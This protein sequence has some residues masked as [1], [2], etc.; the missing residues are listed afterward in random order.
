[1]ITRLSKVVNILIGGS[2][3]ESISARLYRTNNK[4]NNAILQIRESL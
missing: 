1:M 2:E 3:F 4:F